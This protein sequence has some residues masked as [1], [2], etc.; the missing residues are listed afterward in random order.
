MQQLTI[1]DTDLI[2][3]RFPTLPNELLQAW[4]ASD[5]LALQAHEL[6][7]GSLLV[8]N[9]HFGA[10]ACGLAISS[11]ERPLYWVNDSYVAHLALAQNL[12]HNGIELPVTTLPQVEQLDAEPAGIIIKL[13]RSLRLLTWQLDWLNR[14]L[15]QGTPVVIAARQRDMPSTL[16][17][18]TRQL[19]N[20]VR[21]SRA[22]KKARLIYA[23]LSGR[24][25]GQTDILEWPCDAVDCLLSNFPN[26]YGAQRLDLGARLLIQ[27]LGPIPQ[28]VIDLGCGNGVL[29]IAALKANPG[30]QI[31]A[32]DESWDAIRSSQR[33]LERLSAPEPFTLLWNNGLSGIEDDQ[34]DLV[35]CNP[36]FHQ[37]QTITDHIAWQMFQD[38]RRVLKVGGRL[39]IVGNRHLGYHVKLSKL[40][41]GCRTIASNAKFV[42]LESVK[43]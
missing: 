7:V 6:P 41:G 35:L 34:A 40:F 27:H 42:V 38:A 24:D 17:A 3:E 37:H 43:R 18:L 16:P 10:L 4:D 11:P 26:V 39:R 13:P 2:L 36:P 1:N 22:V 20:E 23:Q 12:T 29:S 21:P 28:Q 25:S 15:P 5:E 32:V 8:L 9:D 14:N 31:T 33:N 30:C 19:L